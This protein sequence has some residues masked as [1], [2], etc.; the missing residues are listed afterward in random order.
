M[1]IET[2]KYIFT[3]ILISS[4]ELNFRISK[5]KRIMFEFDDLM[6]DCPF[7]EFVSTYTHWWIQGLQKIYY[8]LLSPSRHHH[9]QTIL[10][11]IT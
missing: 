2:T 10:I 1:F 11:P 4:N 3:V 7:E 5:F 6:T 8:G 9:H